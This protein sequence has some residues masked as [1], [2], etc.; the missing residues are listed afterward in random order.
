MDMNLDD[1]ILDWLRGRAGSEV[2]GRNGTCSSASMLL[3]DNSTLRPGVKS[4]RPSD[5]EPTDLVELF[6]G[7]IGMGNKFVLINMHSEK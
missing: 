4:L 6:P 5:I 3:S 2:P 7:I 1:D